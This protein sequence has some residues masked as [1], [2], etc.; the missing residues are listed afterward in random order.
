MLEIT[1]LKYPGTSN[2]V[3]NTSVKSRPEKL[4]AIDTSFQIVK[5]LEANGN[6]CYCMPIYIEREKWL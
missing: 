1:G 2:K 3:V 6:S 5:S 4:T